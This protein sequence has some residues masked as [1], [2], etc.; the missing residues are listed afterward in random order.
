MLAG[1]LPENRYARV[2]FGRPY[3]LFML[4]AAVLIASIP[5]TVVVHEYG[6]AAVCWYYGLEPEIQISPLYGK[7]TCPIIDLDAQMLPYW[8]AGGVAAGTAWCIP[9]ALSRTR[10]R[11]WLVAP[12]AS[13]VG[14]EF[15]K[16]F[17]E[18]YH[19]AWYIVES[20][21]MMTLTTSIA[22]VIFCFVTIRSMTRTAS[23]D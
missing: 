3:M 23:H 20:Y 4:G 15:C 21:E 6:H 1:L 14:M 7:V 13:V 22:I 18:T 10:R 2:I 8:A 5:A 9:L 19:H 17:L 11:A 16:A 12:L